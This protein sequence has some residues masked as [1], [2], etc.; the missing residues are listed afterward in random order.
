MTLWLMIGINILGLIDVCAH[1]AQGVGVIDL[2]IEQLLNQ[3]VRSVSKTDQTFRDSAAA[4][5][6]VSEADLRRS[7]VT[8]IPEALRMVPGL[9]G[10][11]LDSS[12]W[13]VTARGF[14]GRFANKLLVMIDGRSIYTPMSAGVFWESHDLPIEDI[15]RIEVVRGPGASVWGANAVNGIINIITKH[16]EET[17]DEYVAITG[18]TEERFIAEG[19]MGGALQDESHYRIYAKHLKRDG[20]V[21]VEGRDAG[22]NWRMTR[23]GFRVDWLL[24]SG[25]SVLMEGDYYDGTIDQNFNV[26][27][28]SAP[29]SEERLKDSANTRGASFLMRWENT[30]AL[31]SKFASQFFYEY[32]RRT[33]AFAD[34]QRHTFDFD[35]QHDIALRKHQEFSW[36]IGYRLNTDEF[37][38]TRLTKGGPKQRDLH[39]ISAFLQ[40]QIGLF[41]DRLSLTL[42]TKVEYH[43]FSGL[44]FQPSIKTLW[45]I[46]GDNRLWGSFARAARTPS[47]GERDGRFNIL[48][49]PPFIVNVFLQGNSKVD[50]EVVYALEFGYRTW[51]ADNFFVDVAAFYS[52][53]DKLRTQGQQILVGNELTIKVSD[54]EEAETWGIELAADWRPA[55]WLRW[56]LSYTFLKTKFAETNSASDSSADSDNRNPQHQVSLRSAFN[57]PYDVSVD[58]W[59]RYVDEIDIVDDFDPGEISVD[60]YFTFDARIAWQPKREVELSIIGRN[61][62]DA[63]HLEFTQ[64]LY[65]FPTQVQR[66]VYAQ[67]KWF[68]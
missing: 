29:F 2:S 17:Q 63:E 64:E 34:E 19:R 67:I 58:F 28:E 56:Q 48:G 26:P 43:T 33:D 15:D 9:H 52:W 38:D 57:A 23:G 25:N 22:D 3:K 4:V 46:N 5:F 39:L 8:S 53:Y 59:L 35:F 30:E 41:D 44:Q 51:S 13:A 1:A 16:T 47:R 20:L 10:A 42:G 12:K 18:G 37:N 7:G 50:S 68:F 32:F 6:V 27:R 61:L 31:S 24:S 65:A 36:G 54:D 66:S 62:N 45:K 55:E 49:E 40:D 11:R 60:S 14:N 21:D